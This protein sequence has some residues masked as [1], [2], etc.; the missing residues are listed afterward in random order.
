MIFG[1]YPDFAEIMETLR[2]L[3]AEIN[4]LH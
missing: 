3:E 4:A 2:T 1:R